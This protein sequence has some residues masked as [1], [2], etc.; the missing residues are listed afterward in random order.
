M[1]RARPRSSRI[2]LVLSIAL[3]A[4]AAVGLRGYLARLETRAGIGGDALPMVTAVG[5]LERGTVVGR[6]MVEAHSVPGRYRPPGAVAAPDQV[7]GRV[8][9]ADVVAGEALTAARLAPPG[10]PVAALV[11]PGLRAFPVPAG[12]PPGSLAAGDRVDVLATYP[13]GQPY[14]ETV[15]TGAEVLLVMGGGRFAD[16]GAG[17]TVLLLVGPET[18]GRL[19]HA[20]AFA[21]ISLAVAPP[22]D[23]P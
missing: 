11:P 9:A 17:A 6:S 22:Q 18:A 13:T 5:D 19:A 12:I 1:R 21:D 8:L 20:T 4:L 16:D 23:A 3:A 14:T 15:A 7:V 2:L 10:G